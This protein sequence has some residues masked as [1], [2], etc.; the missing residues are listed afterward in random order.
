MSS[1]QGKGCTGTGK[2]CS[3]WKKKRFRVVP[4]I[5]VSGIFLFFT[6]QGIN[7]YLLP[8]KKFLEVHVAD[9]VTLVEQASKCRVSLF[10]KCRVKLNCIY[11]SKTPRAHWYFIELWF[12]RLLIL[13]SGDTAPVEKVP[14][15][16]WIKLSKALKPVVRDWLALTAAL[17][18]EWGRY[19]LLPSDLWKQ[20]CVLNTGITWYFKS[21]YAHPS[22]MGLEG[23]WEFHYFMTK[24]I[25]RFMPFGH[26]NLNLIEKMDLMRTDIFYAGALV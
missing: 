24:S 25:P 22:K 1:E 10:W 23:C 2:G 19:A 8:K 9:T 5:Q 21:L 15:S 16:H 7:Q 4:W 6:L 13:A 11:G 14:N 12:D 17:Q 3:V 26:R 18:M 20:L